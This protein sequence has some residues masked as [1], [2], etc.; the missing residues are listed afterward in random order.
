MPVLSGSSLPSCQVCQASSQQVS[1]LPLRRSR[2]TRSPEAFWR[3]IQALR[4]SCHFSAFCPSSCQCAGVL[5]RRLLCTAAMQACRPT[6][7]LW[8]VLPATRP[9]ERVWC[10]LS[11]SPVLRFRFLSFVSWRPALSRACSAPPRPTVP[12][13]AARA[14]ASGGGRGGVGAGGRLEA[15]AGGGAGCALRLLRILRLPGRL[16]AGL[17]AQ[18]P[19]HALAAEPCFPA[20]LLVAFLATC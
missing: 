5:V 1:K 6:C 10:S 20:A 11:G 19:S 18:L 14:A 16:Q 13:Q 17:P 9:C 8:P 4:F 12:R 7:G 3:G 2:A 15:E